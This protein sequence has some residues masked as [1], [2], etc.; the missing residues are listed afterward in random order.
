[1]HVFWFTCAIWHGLYLRKLFC[2][3]QEET[4]LFVY[5]R[6][7]GE[8]GMAELVERVNL[9]KEAELQ[10]W[11]NLQKDALFGDT[12]YN[13]RKQQEMLQSLLANFPTQL[14]PLIWEYSMDDDSPPAVCVHVCYHFKVQ[15]EYK[16]MAYR[17][18][19][20]WSTRLEECFRE[21][22]RY[23]VVFTILVFIPLAFFVADICL[24]FVP[25][26]HDC[27]MRNVTS[28]TWLLGL[29]ST[30]IWW[31]FRLFVRCNRRKDTYLSITLTL[32]LFEIT[33]RLLG[34]VSLVQTPCILY[35]YKGSYMLTRVVL[36]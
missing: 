35:S 1:M 16:Y 32:L 26:G 34:V 20:P 18:P 30:K 28:Q 23:T 8:R 33:W 27:V 14:I 31:M 17:T 3:W 36:C 4:S 2:I 21:C 19:A 13:Q 24:A 15:D 10:E 9:P 5:C 22:Y 6:L 7:L 29:A 25:D 11:V 12:Y